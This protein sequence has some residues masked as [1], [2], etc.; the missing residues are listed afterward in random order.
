MA[1]TD[2]T[3]ITRRAILTGIA[4]STAATAALAVPAAIVATSAAASFAANDPIYPIW[5]RWR[6]LE[7]EG[8]RLSVASSE[9][10]DAMPDWAKNPRVLAL[11]GK[12]YK[13]NPDGNKFYAT[14]PEEIRQIVG[15]NHP[16]FQNATPQSRARAETRVAR[17]EA[18]LQAAEAAAEAERERCG[19]A[20]IHRRWDAAID[21]QDP[22]INQIEQS[23][24]YSPVALAAKIDVAFAH[25]DGEGLFVDLPHSPHCSIVRSV[26]HELP[27]DMQ[28]ALARAAAME[29]KVGRLYWRRAEA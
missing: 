25:S 28:A 5:R 10:W 14:T 16:M 4:A 1:D 29:G 18:E 22:L 9:A 26:Y 17:L 19:Y 27:A 12:D 8:A 21:E 20:A 15:M 7:E 23:A 2:N 24:S 11:E 6:D 3:R 13:G